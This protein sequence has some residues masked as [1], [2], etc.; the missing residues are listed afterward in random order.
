MNW[1]LLFFVFLISSHS[2]LVAIT[3]D[4]FYTPHAD[5]T[6][7]ESRGFSCVDAKL[8]IYIY[9]DATPKSPALSISSDRPCTTR[10]AGQRQL[11]GR[12]ARKKPSTN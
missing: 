6:D 3:R 12:D 9:K 2:G 4:F 5:A 7:I 8:Y 11:T 1:P 10:A